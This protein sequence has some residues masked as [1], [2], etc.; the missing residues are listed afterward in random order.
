MYSVCLNESGMNLRQKFKYELCIFIIGTAGCKK[1]FRREA[2]F[3]IKIR[4]KMSSF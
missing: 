3:Y 4:V 1:S 2:T